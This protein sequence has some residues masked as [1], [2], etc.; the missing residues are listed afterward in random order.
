MIKQID[1]SLLFPYLI[2][3]CLR[4]CSRCLCVSFSSPVRASY[5]L[6]LLHQRVQRYTLYRIQVSSLILINNSL[7]TIVVHVVACDFLLTFIFLFRFY[8]LRFKFWCSNG[9]GYRVLH[10]SLAL[11]A[12]SSSCSSEGSLISISPSDLHVGHWCTSL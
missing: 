10:C 1:L 7:F 8:F 6:N 4:F 9:L 11:L 2:L 5:V 3:N 12:I